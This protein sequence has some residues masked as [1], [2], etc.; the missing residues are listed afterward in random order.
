LREGNSIRL[1]SAE[2]T[3]RFLSYTVGDELFVIDLAK[4]R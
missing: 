4:I 2:W 1:P 3:G